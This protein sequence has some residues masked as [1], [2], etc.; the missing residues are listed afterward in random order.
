MLQHFTIQCLLYYLQVVDYGRL[1]TKENF[2]L[3]ALKVVAV[4]YESRSLTRGSK[5]SDLTWKHLYFE[6]LVAEE[7]WSQL[8][9]PLYFEPVRN[10]GVSTGPH[11]STQRLKSLSMRGSG[12]SPQVQQIVLGAISVLKNCRKKRAK[13]VVPYGFLLHIVALVFAIC[14]FFHDCE[15]KVILLCQ[16]FLRSN[17]F[18]SL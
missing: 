14:H 1:K 7:R 15:K 8:V 17:E 5:C 3:L 13:K 9:V 16:V 12:K 2:K 6:K 4:A 18:M 11:D 10:A